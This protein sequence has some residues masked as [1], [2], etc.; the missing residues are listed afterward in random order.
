RWDSNK[1]RIMADV[2]GPFRLNPR[3]TYRLAVDARDENW[4][5][6]STYSGT[7]GGLNGLVLRKAEAGGEFEYGITN[8]LQWTSGLWTARRDFENGDSNRAFADSWSLEL[9]NRLSYRLLELPE[10]RFHGDA[11]GELRTARLLTGPQSRFAIAEGRLDAVWLPQAR[12]DDRSIEAQFSAG[13]TFGSAPFD[14]F[15]MLGMER[16]N[17]LWFR[18]S[19]GARDGR[20]GTAPLG[21]EY[22]LFQIDA[23]QT[24]F[25]F[26]FGRAQIGPFF[27]AGRIGD[28]SGEFGS[29]GWMF[30]TGLEAKIKLFGNLSWVLVYGRNLSGGGA[31]Y[32]SSRSGRI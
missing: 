8:K 13:K 28:P 1:R 6:R 14:N 4:D 22:A 7:P 30:G 9:R 5:L 18:G 23:Y 26:P 17:D 10:H 11:S 29:D 2:S 12:G 3:L 31:F 16:D 21:T 32:T 20:K 15:F 19:L 24:V 27:D 25:K